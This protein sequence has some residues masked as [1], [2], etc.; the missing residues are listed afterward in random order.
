M[1]KYAEYSKM[2]DAEAEK[3]VQFRAVDGDI[4]TMLFSSHQIAGDVVEGI[5]AW[6]AHAGVAQ[7]TGEWAETLDAARFIRKYRIAERIKMMQDEL[8]LIEAQESGDD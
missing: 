1:N 3:G 4:V 5:M 7:G 8:S 2:L 6:A